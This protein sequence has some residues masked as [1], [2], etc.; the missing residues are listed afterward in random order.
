M[1]TDR[2]VRSAFGWTLAFVIVGASAYLSFLYQ[3]HIVAV[4][5]VLAVASLVGGAVI[6]YFD[7]DRK[8]PGEK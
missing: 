6:T 4:F 8:P 1:I 2:N 7:I 5:F 3:L